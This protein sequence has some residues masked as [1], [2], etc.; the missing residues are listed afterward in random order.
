MGFAGNKIRG[1][2]RA[3]QLALIEEKNSK[4]GPEEGISKLTQS[5]KILDN[6]LTKVH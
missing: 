1:I 2:S 6:Q 5:L 4:N 3:A